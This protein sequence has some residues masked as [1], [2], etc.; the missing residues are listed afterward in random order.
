MIN[1]SA[2]QGTKLYQTLKGLETESK[3][4]VMG[5]G[6]TIEETKSIEAKNKFNTKVDAYIERFD[7]HAEEIEKH[8]SRISENME[9][10][11]ILP[12]GQRILIKPYSQNPYQKI[13]VSDSGLIVDTGGLAPMVKSNETGEFIEEEQLI[14]VGQVIEVGPDV[15]QVAIGD[16]VFYRKDTCVPVPF[17]KQGL[18]SVAETQIVV[19]VN[20]K[21]T[22]RVKGL[23]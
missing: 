6:K 10:L 7:T 16:D 1:E 20:E 23:K 8:A 12:Y 22:E 15:R 18:V 3:A 4:F 21:L 2:P 19:H 14:V 5:D 11:E 13:Q 17:F 9:G